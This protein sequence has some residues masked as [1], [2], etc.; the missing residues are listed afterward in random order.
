MT[1]SRARSRVA[2]LAVTLSVTVSLIG[3]TGC[4][5][6]P[7]APEPVVARTAAAPTSTP[8]SAAPS[9]SS[10]PTSG[11]TPTRTTRAKAAPGDAVN[12]VLAISID[13]LNPQAITDLGPKGAPA[14]HRLMRG[15]AYTLNA[16]TEYEMTETLPNHTGMLTSRRITGSKRGHGIDFN[17]D[18]GTTVH[19]QAGHYV[20]SVFDVVHDRGGPTALFAAKTKFEIY[21][22][23]WNANGRA[24]KI[25]YDNGRTKIDRV[26]LDT[27]N[28]RLVREANADL[29]SSARAFTFLHISLPDLAGHE[30]G[31]MGQ[32]YLAA[33]EDTDRLLGTVLDTVAG[34][35]SLKAHTL[36]LLTADH[37]GGGATNH[38]NPLKRQNY[39]VPFMAWGPGVRKGV[40]LYAINSAF[41]TPRTG[42][43]SYAGKQPIR[44]GDIANLAVDALDLPVVPGSELNRSRKLKIFGN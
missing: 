19:Q 33:V 11:S 30:H 2:G 40:N 29:T 38:A 43:P 28:A 35:P 21:E 9:S 18:T 6:S 25:G 13:G 1:L 24:D 20:A 16:R 12:R 39:Q 44:N 22:R 41:K 27:D 31:F 14:F 42:R 7:A 26:V 8:S 37:G 32:E 17:S 23:T 34:K 4:V 3:L 10:T 15:G 5:A 36:V